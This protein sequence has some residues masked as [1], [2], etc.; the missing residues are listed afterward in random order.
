MFP[1]LTQPILLAKFETCRQEKWITIYVS[2]SNF[3]KA[4]P[5]NGDF[6]SLDPNAD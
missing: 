2:L 5:V 3:M 4:I 1:Y 6:D